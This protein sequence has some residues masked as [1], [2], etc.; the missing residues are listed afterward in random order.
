MAL[1]F[2]RSLWG[3]RE[4]E[5]GSASTPPASATVP[6][7]AAIPGEA[8]RLTVVGCG[9]AFGAGGRLQTTY[10]LQTSRGNLLLDC[11]STALIGMHRSNIDPNAVG[12]ILISHLHGDH[13]SGLVWW[14]MHAH[15]VTGR[16]GPLTI[17]GPP[18]LRERVQTTTEALFP[19]SSAIA[20]QYA[21]TYLE[22]ADHTPLSLGDVTLTPFEVHHPS[23]APAYAMRLEGRGR[24]VSF[25]GDTEWV[26]NLLPCSRE[27]DLFIVDCFGYDEDIGF[28]MSWTTISSHLDR[29]GARRIMLTHMGP[30]MLAKRLEVSDPR[31]VLADDG[32]VVEIA[33]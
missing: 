26:E 15:Y 3:R 21:I 10:H 9:D 18:G 24:C 33:D 25:S 27:A 6:A 20:P 29:I 11:G 7:K 31:I 28:H 17:A 2:L 1:S 4:P 32:L 14:L 23:G 22:F 16:T 13:F 8:W 12:A 19:G 5:R 30:D